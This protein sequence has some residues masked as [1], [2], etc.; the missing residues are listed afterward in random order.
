M[1]FPITK[2]RYMEWLRSKLEQERPFREDRCPLAQ[3][4]WELTGVWC[5]VHKR[6]FSPAPIGEKWYPLPRWARQVVDAA[7]KEAGAEPWVSL[8]PAE[9]LEQVPA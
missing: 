3:A 9:L 8:T 7:D 2:R 6:C 4:I 5:S 1:R